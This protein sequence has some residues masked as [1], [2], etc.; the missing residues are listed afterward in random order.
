MAPHHGEWLAG[1]L[2]SGDNRASTSSDRITDLERSSR[3]L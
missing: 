3:C 1:G 2:Q